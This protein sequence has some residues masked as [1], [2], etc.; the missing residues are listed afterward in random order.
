MRREPHWWSRWRRRLP[1]RKPSILLKSLPSSRASNDLASRNLPRSFWAVMVSSPMVETS[2]S[3]VRLSRTPL[4]SFAPPRLYPPPRLPIGWSMRRLP[5]PTRA[6]SSANRE[7]PP[8]PRSIPSR[9]TSR[10]SRH[11]RG[12]ENRG[13]TEHSATVRSPVRRRRGVGAR[14]ETGATP[15]TAVEPTTRLAIDHRESLH[16]RVELGCEMEGTSVAAQVRVFLEEFFSGWPG[17]AHSRSGAL[18]R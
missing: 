16:R 15:A 9:L 4:C 8:R 12:G 7:G 1:P 13:A 2:A 10:I 6:S 11:E 3:V 5:R 14:G 17:C 18:S